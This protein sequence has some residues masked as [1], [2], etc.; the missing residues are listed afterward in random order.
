MPKMR[1]TSPIL[2]LI[3]GLFFACRTAPANLAANRTRN[4]PPVATD[5]PPS[6]TASQLLAIGTPEDF[7]C[8][9]AATDSFTAV[10]VQAGRFAAKIPFDTLFIGIT[11]NT[12]QILSFFRMQNTSP[13]CTPIYRDSNAFLPHAA[14][15]LSFPTRNSQWI[16]LNAKPDTRNN[17]LSRCYELD[18]NYLPQLSID[19][20]NLTPVPSKNAFA[21]GKIEARCSTQSIELFQLT[22]SLI[23]LETLTFKPNCLT[24]S[25]TLTL[26]Y[27]DSIQGPMTLPF[28][29]TGG[30]IY[31]MYREF[32]SA[33][34]E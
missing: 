23:V 19:F 34:A 3:A 33:A 10:H 15:Q 21:S 28:S 24:D 31:K 13:F 20:Y 7:L 17:Q 14:L 16:C 18:S 30:L 22:D 25:A 9:H 11:R 8:K 26:Q 32:Y 1:L 27:T 4:T 29:G 6:L 12:A 2:F 5:L